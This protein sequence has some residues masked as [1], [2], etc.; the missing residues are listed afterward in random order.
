MNERVIH[1]TDRK[2]DYL[3][4]LRA[5]AVTAVLLFHLWPS[6]F[7]GGYVGVDVFFVISGYLMTAMLLRDLDRS[8][9]VH[10]LDFLVRRMRR[11]VPAAALVIIAVAL[12]SPLLPSTRLSLTSQ[13]I[14]AS[15]FFVEN[16]LLSHRAVD[17]LASEQSAG[18][19]QHY[20]SLGVE[21]Q[22]YLIWPLCIL[23]GAFL[24]RR[25]WPMTAWLLIL[26]SAGY[27]LS[28]WLSYRNPPAAYFATH[29]RFWEFV[30]G[31]LIAS[32]RLR[33]GAYSR[34]S[35]VLAWSGLVAIVATVFLLDR[36][37]P[38]PGWIALVPCV[39]A[40]LLIAYGGSPSV[41]W[42]LGSR[43]IA[44][45][46][47]ISYSIYLWHWPLIVFWQ[48][49]APESFGVSARIAIMLLSVLLAVV[50]KI[51]VEDP[52]RRPWTLPVN[53]QG[54]LAGAGIVM[55][56]T[57]TAVIP[58][59]LL[60]QQ[61]TAVADTPDLAGFYP[62]ALA[63]T[64]GAAVPS[65][66][67]PPRPSPELAM[68]DMPIANRDGC[69]IFDA[70]LKA[71]NYG[72]PDGSFHI[73]VIG[74]SHAAQLSDAFDIVAKENGWR[75]THMS[76]AQ[77]PFIGA[78]IINYKTRRPFDECSAWNDEAMKRIVEMKPDVVIPVQS[79]RYLLAPDGKFDLDAF[80]D[81][82]VDRWTA[83]ATEGIAVIPVRDT[84]KFGGSAPECIAEGQT[85]CDRRRSAIVHP[86]DEEAVAIAA[87]RLNLPTIDLTDGIC[88]KIVCR[89]IV[90]NV[91]AWRDSNHLTAT[92]V[93]TLAPYLAQQLKDAIDSKTVASN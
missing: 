73:V 55:L 16:W 23:A 54:A 90:G 2:L 77:C 5:I 11:L 45:I 52:F 36:A 6:V 82:L 8:G 47:D 32:A 15:A 60:L 24:S 86:A 64:A 46:G 39:A 25:R 89:A 10:V 37:V 61:R 92:Y 91:I 57:A 93:R 20:W 75:Y 79:W 44:F 58:L 9:R 70:E 1:P 68:R 33:D 85:D 76:K 27:A 62:G 43:P 21:G 51:I 29:V 38:F 4:G 69:Q 42:F 50:S 19:L 3:Q 40:G 78:E 17:Y 48:S 14:V 28:I 88:E 63:L 12:A 31:G 87:K 34:L 84:P 41:A 26:F 80:T 13:E 53:A 49:I 71:C 81:A 18:V 83:L 56:A 67:P 30:V 65:P 22:F 35:A 72:R 66:A 59:T 7:P 74:D